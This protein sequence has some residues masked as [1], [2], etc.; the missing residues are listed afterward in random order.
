MKNDKNDLKSEDYQGD[1]A[2]TGEYPVLFDS[3]GEDTGSSPAPNGTS[4]DVRD[5]APRA[6]DGD[7]A[8]VSGWLA[9][10]EAEIARLHDRWRE[11][12]QGFNAKDSTIAELREE[13]AAQQTAMAERGIELER[14]AAAC[15]ALERTLAD[16]NAAIT[17]L[18]AQ[19][20]A[21]GVAHE[22]DAAA[23]GA[24]EVEL[25]AA[26][27]EL[28]AAR[29][30]ISGLNVAVERERVAVAALTRRNDE[31]LDA[32]AAMTQRL[33]EL[34]TYIDGRAHSWSGLQ[35]EIAEQKTVILRLERGLKS[36]DAAIEEGLKVKRELEQ[37]LVELEAQNSELHGRRTERE[38]AYEELR[39][40][41]AARLEGAE[42]LK[43]DLAHRAAEHDRL[44]ETATAD[45][46]LIG[47]LEAAVAEK[48]AAFAALE[49]RLAE[50]RA[51]AQD[52]VRALEQQLAEREADLAGSR[53][54]VEREAQL[55]TQLKTELEVKQTS[56]HLL[57]R[58]VH[59]IND[60][61]ASLAELERRIGSSSSA[62]VV[63]EAAPS[64]VD[65]EPT[66]LLPIESF[67]TADEAGRADRDCDGDEHAPRLVGSVGGEDVSYPLVKSEMTIG[68][69]K[70]SDIR[71]PSHFISR[72]HARISTRGIATTIEDV[73]S[74]NG[75]FVNANR[76]KRCVLRDGDVLSLASELELTFVDASH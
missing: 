1:D 45:R 24:A 67:M 6:R 29:A 75:I 28:T 47:T 44:L 42:R 12:E 22:R 65:A 8:E 43:T 46:A 16:K 19:L 33:Q 63:E 38:A 27:G 5:P 57:Q 17:K 4:H 14:S 2:T 40:E 64:S 52:R 7:D 61:G 76:V 71:I 48:D 59:R 50:D 20:D 69:G 73:G 31:L 15:A 49:A 30:E 51:A 13:L 56:L 37:R 11:V 70:T 74:R 21:R 53:A 26:Q 62:G 3:I 41:L 10:L 25:K 54:E 72:L 58:S 39:R 23:L 35:D 18:G 68:R 55:A 60:L 9:H 32:H 66:V 34:E 36:R